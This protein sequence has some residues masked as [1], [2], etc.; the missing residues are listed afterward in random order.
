MKYLTVLKN[1]YKG[2]NPAD[3]GKGNYLVNL[4]NPKKHKCHKT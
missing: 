3:S 1:L 2:R 4:L